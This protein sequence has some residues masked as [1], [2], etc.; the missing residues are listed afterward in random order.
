MASAW[1]SKRATK[2]GGVR[3]RV[4][5]RAGGRESR[6]RYAGSFPTM[7]EAK[8]RRDH[9]AGELAALRMP[10]LRLEERNSLRT[11]GQLGERWKA[12]RV[13][14][15]AG[16]METYRVAL[17]RLLPRMGDGPV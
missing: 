14:V 15:S 6:I 12:S 3:Y 16:T 9:V 2:A 4:E 10:D 17:G 11:L 5:F 13:D 1:I 8:L 7:K